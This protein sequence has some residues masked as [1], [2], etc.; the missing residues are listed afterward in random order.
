MVFRKENTNLN[1]IKEQLRYIDSLH[2]KSSVNVYKL[3]CSPLTSQ[4]GFHW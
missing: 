4:A 2:T 3:V 1:H